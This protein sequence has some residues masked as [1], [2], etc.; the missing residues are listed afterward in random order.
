MRFS[1][2]G[3]RQSPWDRNQVEVART[4]EAGTI[5]P[6][7]ETTRWTYTVPANKKLRICS[8]HAFIQ[9]ES[10]AG[11][12]SFHGVRVKHDGNT[13]LT[14]SSRNNAIVDAVITN[15]NPQVDAIA[16]SVITA[17]TQDNSTGGTVAY[18]AF[19]QAYEYDA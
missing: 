13:F 3:A 10:A 16:G 2:A 6:H 17:T 5:A 9:R 7:A 11:A 1:F 4:Y 19:M 8:A 18:G 15:S 14:A 12:V